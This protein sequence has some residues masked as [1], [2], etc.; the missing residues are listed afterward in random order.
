MLLTV[1]EGIVDYCNIGKYEWPLLLTIETGPTQD[2]VGL[3]DVCVKLRSVCLN[4][5]A[6]SCR[7]A[8]MIAENA[9]EEITKNMD[10]NLVIAES[11]N[12]VQLK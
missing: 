2:C 1:H 5:P 9:L 6:V 11:K 4:N 10:P 7:C 8:D 12:G 3:C